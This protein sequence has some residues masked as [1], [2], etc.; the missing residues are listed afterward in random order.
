MWM[1]PLQ[2]VYEYLITRQ[3]IQY[4][5]QFADKNMKID[6]DLNRLP[7]WM[8]RKTITLLVNS[9]AD[10]SKIEAP[11]GVKVTFRGV[12]NFKMINLDFT[13]WQNGNSK[14]ISHTSDFNANASK[15]EFA[16]TFK[17]ENVEN[18]LNELSVFNEMGQL[19]M[20]KNRNSWEDLDLSTLPRGMYIALT[21]QGN[22]VFRHKFI[23]F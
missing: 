2:E 3:L 20:Q 13:N 12:G 10:F 17:D 1:A 14:M 22:N 7:T 19:M 23:K 18:E 4:S 16:P 6:F 8:R 15:N 21:R 9:A 11:E 5:T